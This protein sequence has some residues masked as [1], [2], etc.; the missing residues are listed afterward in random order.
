[1][2]NHYFKFKQFTIWQDKCAMKVTTD[3]CLFGSLLPH[4]PTIKKV[5]DIGTGTGLLSLM[6]AQQNPTHYIDAVEIEEAAA[7][8][9]TENVAQSP[10]A[11]SIQIHQADIKN[12]T[13]NK[14]YDIIFSNP[15][16]Y[17]NELKGNTTEKNIAHHDDGL[18]LP[19][20]LSTIS[21]LLDSDGAFYLL[22][23]Y[24]RYEE[25]K[26]IVASIGFYIDEAILIK[27]TIKHPYFR[28]IIKGR[29]KITQSLNEKE[30]CICNANNQYTSDFI[31]LLQKYYL[32]L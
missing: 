14:K 2:A 3:A 18:K 23:P 7:L 29:K 16:F 4:S 32:Y 24:K 19:V 22:L 30:I 27:Q 11:S 5:L 25:I 9:A 10:W 28:V 21:T 8:Q 31:Q 20:L 1:L 17:E 6:Y 26:K 13:T 12:Y 15:P